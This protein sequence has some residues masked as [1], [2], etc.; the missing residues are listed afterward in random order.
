MLYFYLTRINVN[1]KEVIKIK[2]DIYIIKNDINN[3][4]YI[5]Q[6]KNSASRF[7]AHCTASETLIDKT[8]KEYGREHFWY[9]ILEKQIENYNERE[10]YWIKY[11]NSKV[12]NGYNILNGGNEPP[13]I[14]GEDSAFATHTEEQVN[15]V[16]KLLK[17]TELS[18][19]EIAKRCGYA[20]DSAIDRI[21]KG[22]MWKDDNEKYPLRRTF[23]DSEMIEE[24]WIKIYD[25]L[26]NT[27]LSH[28]EIANLL[29]LKR[30][31]V[32]MINS[33]KNCF[34]ED[35]EYP[36]RPSIAHSSKTRIQQVQQDLLKSNLTIKEIAKKYNYKSTGTVYGI[37]NGQFGYNEKLN[38][39]LRKKKYNIKP[40]ETIPSEIG[41]T[42][43]IDT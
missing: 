21:N 19:N 34:H 28:K 30:S 41:S 17:E 29:G 9:E 1:K 10:I 32:T 22:I 15:E 23:K 37:N 31:T 18:K 33:G 39:P 7:S 5:G 11:Y 36:I 40:V 43:T 20:D 35:I 8:I 12:P 16:K 6:A 38:Y 2:K 4:V 25:M 3:K 14:K 42:I 27:T 13:I 24:R 26:K